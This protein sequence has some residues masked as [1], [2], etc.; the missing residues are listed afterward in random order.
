MARERQPG[1]K[2]SSS[3]AAMAQAARGPS[4]GF[5]GAWS[6]LIDDDGDIACF[7]L[8]EL[9]AVTERSW[10]LEAMSGLLLARWS[11]VR[12]AL[13]AVH[14]LIAIGSG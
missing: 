6:A 14:R 11:R 5:A 13:T 12:R 4:R 10:A 9:R 2:G 3:T 1:L 7:H 8:L